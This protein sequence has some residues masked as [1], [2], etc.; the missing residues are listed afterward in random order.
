MRGYSHTVVCPRVETF[1]EEN[2]VHGRLD[3]GNR[4]GGKNSRCWS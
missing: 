1:E 4:E 3:R 2:S